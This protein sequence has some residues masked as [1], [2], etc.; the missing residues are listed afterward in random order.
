[1]EENVRS[2][3]ES[4]ILENLFVSIMP[5]MKHNQD[6]E[7]YKFVRD[8]VSKN[9]TQVAM[10]VR[11]V[12]V[13]NLVKELIVLLN[14]MWRVFP[15]S[16]DEGLIKQKVLFNT[17]KANMSNSQTLPF[18]NKEL[19]KRIREAI[20]HNDVNNPNIVYKFTHF[21][22]NLGKVNGSDYIVQIE[23]KELANL[24]YIL[25]INRKN[26]SMQEITY[27][28]QEIH[29]MQDI[30]DYIRII[31][32]KTGEQKPLNENQ[33]DRAY[34]YFMYIA[35]SS[36]ITDNLSK[37]RNFIAL[38]NNPE[39]LILE[40][41]QALHMFTVFDSGST[42]KKLQED[43]DFLKDSATVVNIY[44]AIVTNLLFEIVSSQTNQQIAEMFEGTG[45]NL[46]EDQVRHL[47]NSL[48]HGRYFHDYNKTFYFYDGA[49]ELSLQLK[50]K[51]DDVN[52]LLDKVAKGKKQ[53]LIIT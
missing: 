29:S 20:A 31:D 8:I 51:V 2:L 49:K 35:E 13:V 53:V 30:V 52:K 26:T 33:V 41:L 46:T 17:I 42:F 7:F 21:E 22:L 25:F 5:K 39:F 4:I 19:Y 9:Y 43:A 38:P 34:N 12:C 27:E 28:D 36:K 47:R 23:P 11:E 24:L 45:V 1:M 10:S 6:R 37:S 50:L 48:C 18:N 3:D 40:K 14:Q 32:L 44:F 15:D 16:Y